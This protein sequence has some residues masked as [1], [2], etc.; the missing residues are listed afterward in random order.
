MIDSTWQSYQSHLLMASENTTVNGWQVNAVG[1]KEQK[2]PQT[3]R[4]D[5]PTRL[6]G[7]IRSFQPPNGTRRRR[8]RRTDGDQTETDEKY[9]GG[10][11]KLKGS[12]GCN[13]NGAGVVEGRGRGLGRPPA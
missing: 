2:S 1:E 13:D 7:A 3:K 5:D 10:I 4:V 9:A 8:V 12:V 6:P 11:Y